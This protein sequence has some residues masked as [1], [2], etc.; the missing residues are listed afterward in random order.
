MGISEDI[1]KFDKAKR[2]EVAKNLQSILRSSGG[3][4]RADTGF[5]RGTTEVDEDLTQ[6]T[7]KAEYA[8]Y[9]TREYD[10][11]VRTN[12]RKAATRAGV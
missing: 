4:I 9:Y 6:V 8:I 5:M 11:A 7:S 1:A 10:E 2:A 12:W 3:G